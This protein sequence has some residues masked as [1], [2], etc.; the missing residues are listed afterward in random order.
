M[1]WN[2]GMLNIQYSIENIQLPSSWASIFALNSSKESL[3]DIISHTYR[4]ISELL[5]FSRQRL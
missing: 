4:I 2:L 1:Y 3:T 5:S